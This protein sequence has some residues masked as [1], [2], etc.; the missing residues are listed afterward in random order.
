MSQVGGPLPFVF[1]SGIDSFHFRGVRE[2]H[3]HDQVVQVDNWGIVPLG[4]RLML[5]GTNV[6]ESTMTK[7]RLREDCSY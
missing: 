6:A 2:D 4:N 3:G 5:Q 7:A 1:I